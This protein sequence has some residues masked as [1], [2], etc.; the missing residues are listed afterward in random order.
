MNRRP[1]RWA[2]LPLFATDEQIGTALLG[3]V[4]A[5]EFKHHA[6][7][8]EAHGFPKID[9]IWGGRYVPA[10]KAYF[11]RD[12]GLSDVKPKQPGGVERPDA[13]KPRKQT[14]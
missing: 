14:A 8:L 1:I 4:R 12:Y 13:W 2:D 7:L 10:V 6:A 9:V 5:G 3:A 11:D